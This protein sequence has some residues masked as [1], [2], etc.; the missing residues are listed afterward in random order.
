MARPSKKTAKL[1]QAIVERLSEGE[2]LAQIC[3]DEGMPAARTVREWQQTDE[4]VSAAI[5][6]AREE[7]FDAIA[8]ECLRIA[9]TPMPCKI[10]KRELLGVLKHKDE[11]G[12][13]QSV[14]LPEAELVV[15]EERT[16][17]MLGHRK[18]QIETRLKLLAKWDP[19][20]YGNLQTVEHRGRVTLESL[21]AGIGDETEQE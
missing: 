13:E 9:D 15:T 18:L 1:V 8:A 14:A 3:R 20:R 4:T 17:D 16:E 12:K 11:D 6:R 5:A 2:P 10:E 7:G 19:K 21:V